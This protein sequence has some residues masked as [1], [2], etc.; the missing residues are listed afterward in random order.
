MIPDP[1]TKSLALLFFDQPERAFIPIFSS[2]ETFDQEHANLR[3]AAD[4]AA[5]A[6]ID[7][8]LHFI[9]AIGYRAEHF[10]S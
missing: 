6:L 4:I 10:A 7:V 9:L 5:F 1:G 3:I 2:R 8:D